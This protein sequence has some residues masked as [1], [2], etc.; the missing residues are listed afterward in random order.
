MP[1]S[2][3]GAGGPYDIVELRELRFT[4]NRDGFRPLAWSILMRRRQTAAERRRCSLRRNRFCF[5]GMR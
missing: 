4:T 5:N 1:S 3:P 2:W